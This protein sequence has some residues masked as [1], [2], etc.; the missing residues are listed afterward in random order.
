M[1]NIAFYFNMC[2]DFTLFEE[3]YGVNGET[4][5]ILRNMKRELL[6]GLEKIDK[7]EIV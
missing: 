5:T 1:H 4:K 6:E 3:K 7:G 2:K